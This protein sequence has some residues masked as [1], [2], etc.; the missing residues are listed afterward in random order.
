[1]SSPTHDGPH[2]TH[3]DA[4]TLVAEP[5]P[6]GVRLRRP[7][8][9]PEQ[10]AILSP[11]ALAFVADLHR[12]FAEDVDALLRRRVRRQ[13]ELDAGV[14]LGFLPGTASVRE[15]DW[16]VAPIPEH[17]LDRRVEI[18]GP[19]DRK[20]V[21]NALNSGAKVFMAD[22][23][24]STSPTWTNVLDGQVNLRD[25]VRR[26]I[27]FTADTG[28]RYELADEPAVLTVRPRGWHLLET[29]LEVDGRPVPASLVDA[30]LFLFH[31]AAEMIDRGTGPSLY[32]PKLESHL[33][34]RLWNRV[35]EH[36]QE[37]LGL[38]VGTVK[39]TVLIETL[40]AVFEMDEILFE[41]RDHVVGLNCGRWDYIFSF[42]KC[43]RARPDRL[44]PDRAAVTMEQP[45]MRAYT[46][47]L[48]R[49]CHRRGAFAMGGM[50]AQIPIKD[51]PAANDAAIGKVRADKAREARDG[52]DGTWVAHP[53]LVPVAMEIFDAHLAG[54]R[55][56]L[57][58][59]RDDVQ[60]A[61]SDLLDPPAGPRTLE[62]LR[63]CL[64]VAI[65]YV[66]SWIRGRGC[67][68][69]DH[70]MEDAATAEI[71]RSQVWQWTRWRAELDDG[72]SVTPAV[73]QAELARAM[74]TIAAERGPRLTRSGRFD[75]ART[76][77][78]R[79][80]LDET[81]VPFLTHPAGD[82]LE[83]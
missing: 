12:T 37:R 25:A 74:D 35:L 28:K 53:A 38:P 3:P 30:G 24:D 61:A 72:T 81:L 8:A 58:V 20:M 34:A 43:H 39:V 54:R 55:N 76:L 75:E 36:A 71:A 15:S 46:Q 11:A 41:L 4:G 31:N 44:L 17:L 18:T 63:G 33:E 73:V 50:A 60:V 23:E 27:D 29:H 1:M 82:L 67:V 69:I 6:R 62:S 47:L 13:A 7:A 2:G 70:L 49:T 66:E 22:F 10:G 68:P 65:L 5:E 40:P 57:D 21:I 45:F 14:P 52:H 77:V 59:A 48:V 79:L 51:D 64:R 32:L 42:L 78:E 9:T 56:Q 80:I 26:A 16:R 83:D 19:V